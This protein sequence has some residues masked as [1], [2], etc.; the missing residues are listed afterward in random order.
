MAKAKASRPPASRLAVISGSV[1]R[2]RRLE[3]GTAQVQRGLLECHARLLEAGGG[4]PHHI[5]QPAHGVG[6][7]QQRGRILDR[8]E[9]GE[10]VPVLAHGEI[11]ESQDE[12]GN[13]ERQHGEKIEDCAAGEAGAHDHIRDGGAEH[14]VDDGGKAGVFEAVGDGRHR[15]V[16]AE[17]QAEIVEG[18]VARATPWRA[19]GRKTRPGPRRGG[20]G[21]RQ[22]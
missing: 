6:D 15:Q 17:R 2:M 11:A 7:D 21:R 1:I 19:S 13:R 4:R 12:A 8:I 14:E 9:P 5:G 22:T 20:A 3:R 16:V 10:Q 18:E